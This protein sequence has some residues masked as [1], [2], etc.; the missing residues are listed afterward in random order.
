MFSYYENFAGSALPS[1][2]QEL[3]SSGDTY[4]WNNG[5]T[6]T[7]TGNENYVSIGTTSAVSPAGILEL[8]ITSGS[9]ARPTIELSTFEKEVVNIYV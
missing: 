9:N 4:T 7:Q 8:G 5:I 1:G 2:W 3:T 6:F